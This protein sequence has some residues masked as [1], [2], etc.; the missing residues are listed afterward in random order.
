[1]RKI[2]SRP[3]ITAAAARRRAAQFVLKKMFAGARACDG[4]KARFCIYD[5][6]GKL[7]G[8]RFWVVYPNMVGNPAEIKASEV[9]IVCQRSGKILYVGSARDEG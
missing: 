4:V 7:A 1:M 8:R 3:R 9:V 5:A 6:T 2:K